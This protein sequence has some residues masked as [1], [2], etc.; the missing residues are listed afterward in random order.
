MKTVKEISNELTDARSAERAIEAVEALVIDAISRASNP[1]NK[2]RIKTHKLNS[3]DVLKEFSVNGIDVQAIL[4]TPPSIF[5]ADFLGGIRRTAIWIDCGKDIQFMF[6][7]DQ[8]PEGCPLTIKQFKS[9]G[10]GKRPKL[11]DETEVESY[12]I[13]EELN[14]ALNEFFAN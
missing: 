1:E 10:Y 12:D 13:S 2:I 4:E 11:L 9:R 14:D 8:H 6:E 3:G 7:F 5:F